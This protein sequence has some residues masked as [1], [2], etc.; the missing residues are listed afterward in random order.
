MNH[1]L[2]SG[3][4][5]LSLIS[6][7]LDLSKIEAGDIEMEPGEVCIRDLLKNSLEARQVLRQLKRMSMKI[8]S[9]T[10][11]DYREIRTTN[12]RDEAL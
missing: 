1:I 10:D 8:Q 11:I 12:E 4:H 7:I 6:D 5:L 2:E 3:P 9:I